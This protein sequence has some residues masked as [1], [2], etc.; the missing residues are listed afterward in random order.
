[1]TKAQEIEQ[2]ELAIKNKI[3][4]TIY[5]KW[6]KTPTIPHLGEWFYVERRWLGALRLGTTFSSAMWFIEHLD[7]TLVS[8]E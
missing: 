3:G 8:F 1:M 7:E 6:G 5:V 4:K 2:L